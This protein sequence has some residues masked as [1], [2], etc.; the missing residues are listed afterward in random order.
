MANKRNKTYEAPDMEKMV[1]RVLRGLVRRAEEGDLEAVSALAHIAS[2]SRDR[3][4]EAA[5]AAHSE[6]NAYSWSEIAHELGITRQ[7]AQLRFEKRAS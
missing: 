4:V 6:P 5:V 2:E 1:S 7:A 3:L